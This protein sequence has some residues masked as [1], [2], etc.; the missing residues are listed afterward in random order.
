MDQMNMSSRTHL[1]QRP[2][3]RQDIATITLALILALANTSLLA[4]ETGVFQPPSLDGYTKDREFDVDVNEDG[5][6]ETHVV[7]YVNTAQDII[8]KY[9]TNGKTWAW[10]AGVNSGDKSDI[11]KN[12]A[13]RD[14]N[15]DGKF[16]EKYTRTEEFYLPSCL[17]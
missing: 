4:A 7:K 8:Y 5:I 2:W 15:C 14:S 13:V 6:N 12:Y 11:T 3:Q 17:K 9:T 1:T 16:D 10:G